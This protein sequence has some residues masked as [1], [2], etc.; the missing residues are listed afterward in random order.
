MALR[1]SFSIDLD[2]ARRAHRTRHEPILKDLFFATMRSG[3]LN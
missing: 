2:E 3:I 1:G